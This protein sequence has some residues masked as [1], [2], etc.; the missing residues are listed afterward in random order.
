MGPFIPRSP[1]SPMSPLCPGVPISPRWPL[2]PLRPLSPLG[3]FGPDSP[4]FPGRP[5]PPALPGG[6]TSPWNKKK[7]RVLKF[8]ELRFIFGKVNFRLWPQLVPNY[9]YLQCSLFAILRSSVW[10]RRKPFWLHR[11]IWVRFLTKCN[12]WGSPIVL[13][14]CSRLNHFPLQPFIPS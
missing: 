9:S 6:P 7:E 8:A 14:V 11:H 5:S 3:P 12:F 1:F 13:S 4:T 10:V 2:G